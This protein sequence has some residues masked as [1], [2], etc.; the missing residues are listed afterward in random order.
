LFVFI[1]SLGA[2]LVFI[3]LCHKKPNVVSYSLFSRWCNLSSIF[4]GLL[5]IGGEKSSELDA[6]W[7]GGMEL[8]V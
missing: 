7:I 8:V 6:D 5:N 3:F 4:L 1:A 2:M